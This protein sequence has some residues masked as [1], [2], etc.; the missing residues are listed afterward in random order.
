MG[1][2]VQ[3]LG[4]EGT[5]KTYSLRTLNPKETYYINCDKK[6][7]PFKEWRKIYNEENK[8][9]FKSSSV[10]QIA[11]VI[12]GI[13]S[14]APHIKQI[15]VDTINSIMSDKMMAEMK[16]PG[17]DKWANLAVGIYELYNLV[18]SDE[19]R[20]DL[21][22]IFVG[23]IE[24]YQDNGETKWHLKTVGK[25]LNN[26]NIE[27]K[28]TYTFYTHVER[29][30]GETKYMLM[31][32]SNGYNTARCPEGIFDY[33]IPNDMDYVINEVRKHEGF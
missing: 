31:T 25:M 29:E 24:P 22:V 10:E 19:V 30:G 27:G 4:V 32:Q 13:S 5:G 11:A 28:V 16:K 9:Y 14:K 12:K 1:I 2:A 6:S 8:N 18:N 33:M 7:L 26:L 3:L 17:F 23:H 15:V 20:E 21:I